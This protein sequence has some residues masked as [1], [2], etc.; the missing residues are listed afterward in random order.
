MSTCPS[1]SHSG[2]WPALVLKEKCPGFQRR[3]RASG[4]SANACLIASK[5]PEYVAGVDRE[6]WPIGVA[7]ISASPRIPAASSRRTCFGVFS[8]ARLARSAGT[9]LSST[10]AV[11]PAPDGPATAVMA[12]SGKETRTSCRL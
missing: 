9:R 4:V 7:S 11:L 10:R 12:C 6:F 2:H 3:R 5:A 1:P 8:P